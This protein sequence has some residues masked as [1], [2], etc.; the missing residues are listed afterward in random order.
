ME[1]KI[2]KSMSDQFW[3]YLKWDEMIKSGAC[4]VACKVG[5]PNVRL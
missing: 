2:Q 4:V 3:Y 1:M 5:G